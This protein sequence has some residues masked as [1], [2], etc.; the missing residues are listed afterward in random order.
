MAPIFTLVIKKKKWLARNSGHCITGT[1]Q[2]L[3]TASA[4]TRVVTN[5]GL[6]M[7]ANTKFSAHARNET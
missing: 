7:L 1:H 2:M 6:N 4:A 5:V 3:S